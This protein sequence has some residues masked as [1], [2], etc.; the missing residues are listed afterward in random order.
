MPT[1][2]W[3][4]KM[5]LQ[6]PHEQ[7]MLTV[8][9]LSFTCRQVYAEITWAYLFYRNNVFEFANTQRM[10]IY[11]TSINPGKMDAIRTISCVWNGH[12]TSREAFSLL[13]RSESLRVLKIY[14]GLGIHWTYTGDFRDVAGYDELRTIRGLESFDI[15]DVPEQKYLPQPNTINV[16]DIQKLNEE[17]RPVI[18]GRVIAS[19]SARSLNGNNLCP[20]C[21][22]ASPLGY[23]SQEEG[24]VPVVP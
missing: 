13:A 15:Y 2:F 14:V 12:Y 8:V 19:S 10:F 22:I 16:Y 17:L 6:K 11:L 4:K 23:L 18:I 7:E 3:P 1:K 24:K 21:G 5:T 20:S 9:S